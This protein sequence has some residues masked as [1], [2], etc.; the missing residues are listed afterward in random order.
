MIIHC[1]SSKKPKE[2]IVVFLQAEDTKLY[3]LFQ[4]GVNCKNFY[5]E[6]VELLHC[7]ETNN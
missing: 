1:V 4:M 3:F 7:Y 2:I 6:L 5:K